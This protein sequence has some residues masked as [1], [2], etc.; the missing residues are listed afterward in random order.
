MLITVRSFAKINIGLCIG[1]LRPD[2]YH[3]L[4]TLYQTV[5]LEDRVRL[6]VTRGSGIEIHCADARVP[7]DSSNTCYKIV[8]RAMVA[9]RAR[10]RVLIAIDKRLPVRGGLGGASG[11]AVAALI[12][13]QRALRKQLPVDEQL[14]LAAEVG[15]DLPL[16]LVGGTVLGIGRGEEVYPLLDFPSL[17]CV[18]ATPQIEVSTPAAFKQWDLLRS[19]LK[20][21]PPHPSDR[22]LKFGRLLAASLGQLSDRK[23]KSSKKL[24]G[25][26]ALGGRGRGESLLLDL[27]RTG[28]ENDFEQVVFP[29]Y[30]ALGEVKR[31]LE[32]AGALYA[33]LSGSGS[34][35]YG[36]FRTEAAAER[37]TRRLGKDA[38]P[39]V[40]TKTLNRGQYWKRMSF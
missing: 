14:R 20:L 33:Q 15:S 30:P 2:G 24:S 38:V 8:E 27:V 3:D 17:P 31:T 1:G 29:K 9:L 4:R 21:T 25:V 16:F 23:Y 32:R 26:L 22:I 7:C 5:G 34:A 39:V 12:A 40:M 18:I 10:G 37:A 6:Q 13:L 11:N 35:V 28:I 19:A 36:L